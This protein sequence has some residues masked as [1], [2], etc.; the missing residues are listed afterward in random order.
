TLTI[1]KKALLVTADDKIKMAGRENP[2]LT[3]TY[4][5]LVG[6]DTKDSICA[7]AVLPTSPVDVHQLNRITTYTGVQLNGGTNVINASPGQQIILTGTFNS[8]YFDTSNYCPGCITQLHI[9]M[10]N[11]IGR[12]IFNDCFEANGGTETL[13]RTFAA[14]AK[15]GTY[16]ITQESTWWFY[17]GQFADPAHINAPAGAIALVIVNAPPVVPP[18]PKTIQQLNRATTYTNVQLNGG[19]NFIEAAPGQSLT[20]TGN[21]N[22]VY[23]DP[24]NFCPGCITQIYIGMSDA[25][26]SGVAFSD[27]YNVSGQASYSGSFDKTFTAPA[28]PGTYYITQVSSWQFNCYDSAFGN[29]GN[30]PNA[31]IAV[32]VVTG[33]NVGIRAST[34]AD[35]ASSPGSY[36]I[37]LEGCSTSSPNY[38]ITLQNGTLSVLSSALAANTIAASSEEVVLKEQMQTI[39]GDK[40]YPNPGRAMVRLE[41]KDEVQ[42]AGDIQVSDISGKLTRIPIKRVNGKIYEINISALAPGVY[43]INVRSSEGLKT[44]RLVKL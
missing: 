22:S 14:P 20:L 28:S 17:C 5:G 39:G 6:D 40:L 8:V 7:P 32:V 36:P 21:Y 31:A 18:S 12:N 30:D 10:S 34:T 24:R 1:T 41:L 42:R 27:C 4:N 37:L 44:F 15:P 2:P 35:T 23:S 29:P 19:T 43:F 13:N 9:G 33:L 26:G 3:I 38:E 25:P 11:E 16:Y